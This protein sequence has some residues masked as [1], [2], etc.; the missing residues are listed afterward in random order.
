[1]ATTFAILHGLVAVALLGAITHQT[2]AVWAPSGV[3][4][5]SFFGRF[6]AVPSAAFANAIILLCSCAA[7]A[8]H[9]P[10]AGASASRKDKPPM[11]S[12]AASAG[13]GRGVA[14]RDEKK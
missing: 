9:S 12:A 14:I 6:R 11:C 7:I 1:M 10:A 4:P 3:P 13:S 2:L 5:R 8:L